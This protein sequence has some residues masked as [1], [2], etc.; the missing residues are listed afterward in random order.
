MDNWESSHGRDVIVS[1]TGASAEQAV[2]VQDLT[3]EA[4]TFA[5]Y[6]YSG[7]GTTIADQDTAWLS[8]D[9][10][11]AANALIGTA[12]VTCWFQI[13]GTHGA[14]YTSTLDQPVFGISS[15]SY[16]SLWLKDDDDN[17]YLIV[18]GLA[19]YTVNNTATYTGGAKSRGDIPAI[20]QYT[21]ATCDQ[22][23]YAS[24]IG[25]HIK[26]VKMRRRITTTSS[27]ATAS[28]QIGAWTIGASDIKRI[29]SFRQ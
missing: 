19:V 25:K 15:I 17:E 5:Q 14:S 20:T 9:I 23:V 3:I 29:V 11:I 16:Y 13:F 8:T 7:T 12:N 26:E 2:I 18:P 1:S 10:T 28:T 21:H 4:V 24:V 22:T 27:S 6:T